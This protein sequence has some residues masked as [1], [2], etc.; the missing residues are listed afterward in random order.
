MVID[1]LVERYNWSYEEALDRF[2]NS[3][4][5]KVLSDRSTGLFTF[6]PGEIIELFEHN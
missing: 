6:A 1:A 2:Y 3:K 4:T 5:C